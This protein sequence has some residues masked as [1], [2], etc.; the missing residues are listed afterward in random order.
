MKVRKIIGSKT[1]RLFMIDIKNTKEL[2][3]V[4]I[5]SIVIWLNNYLFKTFYI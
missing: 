5:I 2:F 3:L 4:I 1:I